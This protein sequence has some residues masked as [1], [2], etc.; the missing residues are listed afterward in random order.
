MKEVLQEASKETAKLEIEAM[1]AAIKAEKI[2]EH[3][4]KTTMGRKSWEL[5]QKKR[6]QELQQQLN[7]L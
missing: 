1:I 2:P 5:D 6:V 3:R 4:A 7:N